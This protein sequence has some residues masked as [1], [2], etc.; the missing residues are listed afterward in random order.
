[1]RALVVGCAECV[2][3]DVEEAKKLCEFEMVVCVK[4]AGIVWP[5]K[6][7]YWAGLHPEYLSDYQ[8]QRR[9]RGLPNGY[10]T[11]A[12]PVEELGTIPRQHSVDV[13]VPYRWHEK[14]ITGASGLYG[15]KVA[16]DKGATRVVLAGVPMDGSNHFLRKKPW[17]EGKSETYRLG[18]DMALP[19]IR[20]KVKSMSGWTRQL[21]GAPTAEWIR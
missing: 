5:T 21:L 14:S 3:R 17:S 20:G 9:E 8:K 2:D 11:V 7:D 1:M 18:W 19:Y 10:A 4:M 12:P 6:F 13:R 15:A 16:L